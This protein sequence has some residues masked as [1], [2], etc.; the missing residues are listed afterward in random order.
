[1]KNIPIPHVCIILYPGYVRFESSEGPTGSDPCL[2]RTYRQVIN[3]IKGRFIE[4]NK[5]TTFETLRAL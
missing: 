4:H 2:G 3:G 5:R 1:M